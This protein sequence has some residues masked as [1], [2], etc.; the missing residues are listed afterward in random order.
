M[1]YE[2]GK[3]LINNKQFRKAYNIFSKLLTEKKD[4]F[5]VNF[6]M[7]KLYYELNDLNNS[8]FYFIM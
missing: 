5:R 7:G 3:L 8:I 4:N 6:Q 2:T 1:S